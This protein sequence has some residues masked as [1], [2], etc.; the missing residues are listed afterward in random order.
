MV[1]KKWVKKKKLSLSTTAK[2]FTSKNKSIQ[3]VIP[4]QV[5]SSSASL[6]QQW[7]QEPYPKNQQKLNE[8][9]LKIL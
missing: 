2:K 7:Q 9:K 1:F 5:S 6:K 4:V 8:K 3:T